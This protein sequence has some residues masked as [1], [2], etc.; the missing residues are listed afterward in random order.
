MGVR[1]TYKLADIRAKLEADAKK[2][3]K[4]ILFRLQYLGE[5]CVAMAR[6]LDTY[7]DQTGNLRNSVGYIIAKDGRVVSN[8]FRKS[9]SVTSTT[10][11]GKPKTTKGS[12]DGLKAGE[13]LAMEVLLGTKRGY[14]LIVVAGMAYA[15]H[16]ET[17]GYDVLS[18]AEQ[19]A[20]KEMPLM[21]AKLKLQIQTMK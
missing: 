9:A 1:P 11:S 10:Q 20:K 21:K 14:I 6:S 5:E 16:V 15:E 3:E 18:S 4:A 12:S 17:M 13:A 7:I 2:I 8:N 19:F